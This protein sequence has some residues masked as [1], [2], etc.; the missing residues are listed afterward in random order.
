MPAF[1]VN[2]LADKSGINP[3]EYG[4]IATLIA[5]A[6]AAIL[7]NLGT[8]LTSVFRQD[9]NNLE[10][11]AATFSTRRGRGR[12][13]RGKTLTPAAFEGTTVRK[14]SRNLGCG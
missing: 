5:V 8:N 4:L 12:P 9:G 10:P 1:L 11:W 13:C 7:G 3:V 6:A 14:V 2:L